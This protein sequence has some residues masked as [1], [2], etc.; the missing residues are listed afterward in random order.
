VGHIAVIKDPLDKDK[1]RVIDLQS[2]IVKDRGFFLAG[3][4]ALS[5][6]IGHRISNQG[7]E[8]WERSK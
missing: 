1:Q 6:R 7:A 8:D 4:T 5:I 2:A 3:G